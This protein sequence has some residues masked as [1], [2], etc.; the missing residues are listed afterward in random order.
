MSPPTCSSKG[1]IYDSVFLAST[2][3]LSAVPQTI[4]NERGLALV[5]LAWPWA[6][7]L[8]LARYTKQ[9]PVDC[10]LV[11]RFGVVQR[12]SDIRYMLPGLEQ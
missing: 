8:K 6:V 4:F 3:R 12:D 10:A 9:D 7:A 11:L 1:R 5:A 2:Y